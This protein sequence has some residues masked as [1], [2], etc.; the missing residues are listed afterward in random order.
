[1]KES[2]VVMSVLL[3]SFL[4]KS[5]FLTLILKVNDAYFS[6]VI[7]LQCTLCGSW[8]VTNGANTVGTPSAQHRS[9]ST[10]RQESLHLYNIASNS[11]LQRTHLIFAECDGKG[12]PM[13]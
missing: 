13:N 5:P 6:N 9:F 2:Q 11:I 4:Y 3:S 7:Q 12:T 8:A 1:M 10:M